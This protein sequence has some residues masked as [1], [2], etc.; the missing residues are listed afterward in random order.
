MKRR[1]S[2]REDLE[3]KNRVKRDGLRVVIRDPNATLE[4]KEQA[5][6]QIQTMPRDAAKARMRKRC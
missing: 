4:Q 3:S 5:Q 6:K 1:E 2:R